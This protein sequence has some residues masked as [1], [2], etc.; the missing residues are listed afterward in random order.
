MENI[1]DWKKNMTNYQFNYLLS[2][3]DK[4]DLYERKF[5]EVYQLVKELTEAGKS[6]A[7]ILSAVEAMRVSLSDK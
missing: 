7:E 3:H 6:P 4:A 2:V 1:E 5:N